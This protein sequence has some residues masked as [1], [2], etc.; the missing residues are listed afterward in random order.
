MS[1][2][3]SVKVKKERRVRTIPA[4]VLGDEDDE[5][6]SLAAFDMGA[7]DYLVACSLTVGLRSIRLTKKATLPRR[8]ANGRTP[9]VVSK[10]FQCP[11]DNYL[12]NADDA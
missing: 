11:I 4:I 5:L 7:A 2:T 1:D 3:A 8:R 12:E 6:R 10:L 9:F